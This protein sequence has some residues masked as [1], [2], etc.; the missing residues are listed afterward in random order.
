MELTLSARPRPQNLR[1]KLAE[2]FWLEP[3]YSWSCGARIWQSASL[4]ART[5]LLTCLLMR[6]AVVLFERLRL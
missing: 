5:Q 4:I 2:L 1:Q 3:V 6:E